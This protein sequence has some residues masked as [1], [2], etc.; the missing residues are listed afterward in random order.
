[1]E[2]VLTIELTISYVQSSRLAL[3]DVGSIE[4][5]RGRLNA[6]CWRV[7][8]SLVRVGFRGITGMINDG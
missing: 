7:G 1:M 8:R 4:I 5:V 3:T 6:W 2:M